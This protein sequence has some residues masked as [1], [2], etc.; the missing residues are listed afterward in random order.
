VPL[1]YLPVEPGQE[2]RK[3]LCWS[4]TG[5]RITIFCNQFFSNALQQVCK[6]AIFLA[7]LLGSLTT[8]LVFQGSNK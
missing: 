7:V 3:H 6:E 4:N 2:I 1:P 5:P 8:S